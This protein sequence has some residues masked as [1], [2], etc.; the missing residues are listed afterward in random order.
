MPRTILLAV[1]SLDGAWRTGDASPSVLRRLLE[2]VE[3]PAGPVW[4]DIPQLR[5]LRRPLPGLR[6]AA[7]ARLLAEALA[8]GRQEREPLIL[9]GTPALHA[10]LLAAP[11][12]GGLEL[13]VL[14]RPEI[15]LGPARAT[16][17]APFLPAD[18]RRVRFR[19]LSARAVEEGMICRY[20][21]FSFA[22]K[23]IPR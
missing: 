16:L 1:L 8:S 10:A 18:G 22:K 2:A 14:Q 9:L 4:T 13:L 11:P 12:R 19:L 20:R 21:S 5:Q 15:V 6:R 3:R 7:T 23:L 17:A